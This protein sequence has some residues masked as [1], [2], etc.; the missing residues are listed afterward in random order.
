[1]VTATGDKEEGG[2]IASEGATTGE[3]DIVKSKDGGKPRGPNTIPEYTA[4]E[5]SKDRTY[6]FV[7]VGGD[8]TIISMAMV[9]PYKKMVQ[10]AGE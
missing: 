2:A 5:E 6:R 1:M 3:G 4:E 10:H 7:S 9:E 8:E